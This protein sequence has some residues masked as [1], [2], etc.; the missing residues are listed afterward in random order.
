MPVDPVFIFVF[1]YNLQAFY[2]VENC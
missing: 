2:D 1:I